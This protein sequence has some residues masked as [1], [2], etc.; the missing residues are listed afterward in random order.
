LLRKKVSQMQN[1]DAVESTRQV[2]LGFW[3]RGGFGTK[4]FVP[5]FTVMDTCWSTGQ[6]EV[7]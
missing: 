5:H 7:Q 1:N 3:K 4:V 6:S 2:C